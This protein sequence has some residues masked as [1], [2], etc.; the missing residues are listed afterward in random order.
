MN[1]TTNIK[2]GKKIGQVYEFCANKGCCPTAVEAKIG[3]ENGLQINDDFG[4]KVKLT[5]QNL[6]DLKKF[7]DNRFS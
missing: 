4:G 3:N 6:K 7:L 5:D 1:N 2:N